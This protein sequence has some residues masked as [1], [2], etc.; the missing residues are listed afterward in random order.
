MIQAILISIV[1]FIASIDEYT[2]GASMMGRPL[3]ISPIVGLILGDFQTG[4][5]IGATLE[6]M[7]MGSIMVGSATPPEVYASSVLGTAIAIKTGQG[8]GT[9][10]ALALPLSIFLQMWRN[11]C[12][13]IGASF[14]GKQ[15]DKALAEHN[16]KKAKFW[17][18][19][20]LPVMV[21]IPS[22][23]LVFVAY[24]FG[25][26]SI[27]KILTMI[28]EAVLNGF[29]IAAG[30]LSCVGLALLIKMMGNKKLIPFLFLGFIAV[31]YGKMDVIGVAVA[32]LSLAFILV[33]MMQF[34]E[35]DDF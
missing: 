30:V 14:G 22:M 18:L 31:M 24:Y 15:I 34:A 28:P 25:T 32:G 1:A 26:D 35:E 33:N 21:G 9:A 8:V 7:F 10:V 12:Y 6:L 19:T 2:F 5:I 17:H 13:A 3:F 11:G 29:D 20:T 4:V 23:L 16:I 27:N